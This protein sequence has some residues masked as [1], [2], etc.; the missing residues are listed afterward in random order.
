MRYRR[1]AQTRTT[2]PGTQQK[3]GISGSPPTKI[4]TIAYGSGFGERSCFI[5]ALRKRYRALPSGV[6][7]QARR[8]H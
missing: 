2:L 7:A 5:R 1:Y 6:H 3:L 8:D 4:S